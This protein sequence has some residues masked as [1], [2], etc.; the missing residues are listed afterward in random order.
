MEKLGVTERDQR[1]DACDD[2]NPAMF[3]AAEKFLKLTRVE[4]RLSDR[5]LRARFDFIFKAFDFFV[6][7]DSAGIYADANTERRRLANRI[8]TNIEAVIQ[9]VHHVSQ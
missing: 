7:I 1:P 6:K 8:V 4:H 5:V 2:R 3:D 9:L